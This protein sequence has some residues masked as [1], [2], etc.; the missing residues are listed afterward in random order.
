MLKRL[1]RK[2]KNALAIKRFIRRHKTVTIPSIDFPLHLCE[3][4]EYVHIEPDFQI[5]GK[6]KVII[7]R[8]VIIARGFRAITSLHKSCSED[9]D[10]LPYNGEN[11]M[12]ADIIIQDNVWIGSYVTVMAGVTIE[13]GAIVGASAVVT[14]NV[15]KGCIVAGVP[16]KVIKIR[17]LEDY[18]HLKKE[19]RLYLIA[20]YK[21]LGKV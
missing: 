14:K 6:G 8:N 1:I 4:S 9:N 5:M 18:E 21:K 7:G 17:N 19:D 12:I 20:K 11:D 10:M 13:E 16:A 3:L 15:H 2:F